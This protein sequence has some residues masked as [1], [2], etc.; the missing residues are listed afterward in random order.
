MIQVKKLADITGHKSVFVITPMHPD[1]K[2]EINLKGVAK[3]A[4]AHVG[5]QLKKWLKK[6]ILY[7]NE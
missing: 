6:K 3:S 2:S 7:I 1:V 5:N 4:R